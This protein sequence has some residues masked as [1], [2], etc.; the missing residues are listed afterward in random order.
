MPSPLR[1]YILKAPD[2]WYDGID[3]NCDKMD[4]FDQD[5]DGFVLD[6]YEG[7]ET[8]GVV[9]TGL[10]SGGTVRI[11]MQT[12]IQEWKKWLRTRLIQTVM[13][14]NFVFEIKMQTGI[15]MVK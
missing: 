7:I 10:L 13:R 6:D 1:I 14:R 2:V 4:D 3:S 8:L 15:A 12:E 5:G 9:G 11:P